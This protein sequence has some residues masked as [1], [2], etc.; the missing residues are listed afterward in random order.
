MTG[1]SPFLVYK[2]IGGQIM[3]KVAVISAI[4]DN[5]K[6]TQHIFNNCVSSYKEMVRGRMGL[7]LVN[8]GITVI[9]LT[10]VG[11]LDDI[12]SLT[13]KLGRISDV[14]VKTSISKKEFP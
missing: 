9:T 8:E 4:L 3:K 5:P 10:V 2:I 7:P 1:H 11:E 13:G 6:D 12:N 14:Q